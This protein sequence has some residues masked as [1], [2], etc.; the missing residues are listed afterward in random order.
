MASIKMEMDKE[1]EN[2]DFLRLLENYVKKI[3]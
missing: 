3:F 1:K 2:I